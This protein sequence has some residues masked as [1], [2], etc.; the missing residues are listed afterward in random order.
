MK[1]ILK[2][3]KVDI[4]KVL[5]AVLIDLVLVVGLALILFNFAFI[6]LFKATTSFGTAEEYKTTLRKVADTPDKVGYDLTLK[7]DLTYDVYINEAKNFYEY[8]EKEIVTYYTDLA[9]KDTD[10]KEEYKSR[11]QDLELI[12]NF[13]FLGLDY[14]AIPT[15]ETSYSNAYFIYKFDS[16]NNILWNEYAIDHP[17]TQNLNERG[18]AERQDYVYSAYS[19]L[20]TIL[21]TLDKNYAKAN[22]DINLYNSLSSMLA[23]ATS[24]LIF[25]MTIPLILKNNSTIGKKI[26]GY[27]YINKNLT[28]LPWYKVV[29]KTSVAMVLPILGMFLFSTY[30]FI[31]LVVFPYFINIMY[32]LLAAKDKDLLDKLFRMK[33]VNIKQSL[34]F[35]SKEAEDEYLKNES[36][37]KYDEKEKEYTDMLSN[38]GTLD[39]KS[40]EEKIEDEQRSIE[41]SN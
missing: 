12:F 28:T 29:C 15:E 22:G 6:P 1:E 19:S 10:V 16:D 2:I 26:F 35:T 18:I 21:A 36:L 33:M 13:T 20:D 32:F 34:I 11:F 40:I 24:I 27:G 30:S 8:Y 14:R 37:D 4:I 25:Y 3:E 23:S 39:L 17:R 38:M 41:K 9:L 31:I 7:S 5:T